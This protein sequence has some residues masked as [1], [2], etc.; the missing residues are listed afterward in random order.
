MKKLILVTLMMLSGSLAFAG[1]SGNCFYGK[2]RVGSYYLADKSTSHTTCT[3]GYYGEENS[4]TS[5]ELMKSLSIDVKIDSFHFS[6]DF[7]LGYNGRGYS[8]FFGNSSVDL[9]GN[10]VK[11]SQGNQTYYLDCR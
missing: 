9:E 8:A 7:L 5:V 10:V 11:V 1:D 6:G 2:A 4:E 3:S